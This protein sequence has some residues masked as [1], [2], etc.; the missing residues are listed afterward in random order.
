LT[1][2]SGRPYG[3]LGHIAAI[4][5]LVLLSDSIFSTAKWRVVNLIHYLKKDQQRFT[6]Y[7]GST[8]LQE[9]TGKGHRGTFEKNI[10]ENS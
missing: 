3:A 2:P 7:P 1:C 4:T 9:K 6:L 10:D 5:Q 8:I